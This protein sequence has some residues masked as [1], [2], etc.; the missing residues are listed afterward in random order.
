LAWLGI[1]AEPDVIRW[2][3]A[4]LVPRGDRDILRI[5]VTRGPGL[6]GLLPRGTQ[7]PTIMASLA[8]LPPG[9]LF[10]RLSLDIAAIR[11]NETS[12]TS[13]L[14]TLGYL[15]AIIAM[16]DAAAKGHDDALF[17]NSAG[18]VACAAVGNIF[19]LFGRQL[20]T[21]PLTDGVLPGIMRGFV[22][23]QC[24]DLD[25]TGREASF[26]LQRLYAADAVFVTNSL[27]LIAP[28][29]RIGN[30]LIKSKGAEKVKELQRLLWR[31]IAV[32]CG[33]GEAFPATEEQAEGMLK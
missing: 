33:H 29:A 1:D 26:D 16:R 32:E 9:A 2:A 13:A 15:D 3:V 10:P 28:V 30:I 7:H 27:R 22:L 11:R 6:R 5:T 31:A 17:L 19:A 18:R 12:P 8:P 14:K 20:W 25:L 4:A 21:P 23:A 24:G